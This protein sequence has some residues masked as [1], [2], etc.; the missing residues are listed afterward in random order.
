MIAMRKRNDK[1]LIR[2]KM[3]VIKQDKES[4]EK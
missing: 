3:D 2:I 4:K 1:K